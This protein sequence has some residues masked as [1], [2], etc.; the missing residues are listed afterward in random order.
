M[1]LLVQAVTSGTS[2][3]EPLK[4]PVTPELLKLF[5][6]TDKWRRIEGLYE[7]VY[8]TFNRKIPGWGRLI[9]GRHVLILHDHYKGSPYGSWRLY[10]DGIRVYEM[11]EVT[12]E[13]AAKD[14]AE[15]Y[16]KSDKLRFIVKF[17]EAMDNIIKQF[18]ASHEK[19]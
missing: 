4:A 9:E 15:V 16:M 6:L 3:S 10:L 13:R 5:P 8:N 17:D 11:L 18:G 2:S 1:F 12:N 7:D 14:V 19:G